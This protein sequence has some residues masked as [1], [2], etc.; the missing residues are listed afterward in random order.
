MKGFCFDVAKLVIGILLI[1]LIGFG[2]C[3]IFKLLV[4]A[5]IP[6]ISLFINNLIIPFVICLIAMIVCFVLNEKGI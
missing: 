2:L 6:V 3:C 5:L 1:S 4:M